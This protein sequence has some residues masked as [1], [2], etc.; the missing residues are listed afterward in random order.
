MAYTAFDYTVPSGTQNG[1]QLAAS[2]KA[3]DL[4]L[5]DPVALMGGMTGWAYSVTTSTATAGVPTEV[6]FAK[7]SER[8]KE[9]YSY[10]TSGLLSKRARYYSTNNGTNYDAIVDS[11]GNFVESFS[12]D[13]SNNLVSTS[14]GTST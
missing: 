8:L 14:W 9:T 3:N 5:R 13:G 4:A 7:G 6:V 10:G 2:A 1:S 11:S 12:Y